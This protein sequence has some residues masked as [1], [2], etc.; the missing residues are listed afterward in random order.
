MFP[1]ASVGTSVGLSFE[2]RA[3]ASDGFQNAALT[4]CVRVG[5]LEHILVRWV[6]VGLRW[7]CPLALRWVVWDQIEHL[8]RV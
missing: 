4:V 2:A 7:I 8:A 6:C 3:G 1:L 5:L